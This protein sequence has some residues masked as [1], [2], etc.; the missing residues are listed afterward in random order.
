MEQGF[1]YHKG[2]G[3][4]DIGQGSGTAEDKKSFGFSGE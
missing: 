3:G 2:R 1:T 4:P